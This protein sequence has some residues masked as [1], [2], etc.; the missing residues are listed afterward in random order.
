VCEQDRNRELTD[1]LICTEISKFVDMGKVTGI[2]PP[3]SLSGGEAGA[4]SA[5]AETSHR[6][7]SG[8]VNQRGRAS[9]AT[10][11]YEDRAAHGYVIGGSPHGIRLRRRQLFRGTVLETPFLGMLM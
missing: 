7:Q 6:P 11:H 9:P 4:K 5:P 2:T 10:L 8:R 3:S 1:T